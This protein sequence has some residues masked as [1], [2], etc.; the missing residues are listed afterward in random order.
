M[1]EVLEIESYRVLAERVVGATITGG[2]ADA[3]SAKKLPSPASWSRAV[4]GRRVTGVARRGKLM[5]IETD[6]VTLGVRFGMTGVLLLDDVAGIEGLFY[7][8]HAYRAEW[9]RGGLDFADHRRLL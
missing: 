1:P 4:R 2:F 7:G 3:Y 8:P 6:G 5:L 9:I